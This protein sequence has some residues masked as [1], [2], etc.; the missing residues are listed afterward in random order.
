MVNTKALTGVL[1]GLALTFGLV[2]CGTSGGTAAQ[3]SPEAGG[4]S[5]GT[6]A[7]RGPEAGGA[8]AGGEANNGEAPV[9]AY[10]DSRYRYRIDAP[11]QMTANAD[12]TATYVGP[13][14][15]L[16]VAVVQG[17]KAADVSAL[18]RDDV[19]TL[20]SSI[21]GFRLISGPASTN[22]NGRKMEKFIYNWTPGTSPVTGKPVT[23]VA[24][25]YYV[26]KDSQTVAVI[27]YGI[28]SN[29]YDPQGADDLASTFQWQ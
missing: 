18:G 11:G 9:V 16:Q 2:A 22:V 20:S 27:T 23:L 14:E 15:R 25:R 26:P 13:S 8:T 5:G 10:V 29:Q 6:A 17:V 19:A 24:V 4:A 21:A 1:A 3:R 12:G 28:V 7:Q